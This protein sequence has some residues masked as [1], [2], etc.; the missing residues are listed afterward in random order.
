MTKTSK[1]VYNRI[2]IWKAWAF[3]PIIFCRCR[4]NDHRKTSKKSAIK[5]IQE[6]IHLAHFSKR[7][8]HETIRTPNSIELI[9]PESWAFYLIED[10]SP[11]Y[12]PKKKPFDFVKAERL[13]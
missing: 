9:V 5:K 4:V 12:I 1:K 10:F 6:E 7:T 8:L 2:S 13:N 3:L 11:E